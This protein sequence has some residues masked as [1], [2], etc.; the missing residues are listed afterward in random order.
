MKIIGGIAAGAVL[1]LLI[2][3]ALFGA[4]VGTD[5]TD[6]GPGCV[7]RPDA[8]ATVRPNEMITENVT[9]DS[10]QVYVARTVVAV[11]KGMNIR[12]R[13]I[14]IALAVAMQESTLNPAAVNGRS[15]GLFQQQGELYSDVIKT[16]PV[17]SSAAFYRVLVQRVPDYE[18]TSR[19][20]AAI[21]QEVQRA[22]A[23]AEPYRRWEKWAITLEAV[24]YNGAPRQPPNVVQCTTGVGGPGAVKVMRQ[25]YTVQLPPEAEHSGTLTFPNELTAKAA[26]A[27]LSQLGVTYAWGGGDASG[28]T[29]GKRDGGAG[30][31]HGDFNKVGFDCSGLMLYAFAQVGIVLP[32]YSGDQLKAARSVTNWD[33]RVPGDLLFWGDPVHHVAMYLGFINGTPLMIE[34]Q[35]SG[36]TV[37]VAPV[38]V[39]GDFRRNSVGRMWG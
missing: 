19:D 6:P 23:G 34:A 38:R 22:G 7:V 3:V 29:K 35:Q 4:A 11:G 33:A 25:G 18:D 10:N 15:V 17:D 26:A 36:T 5:N 20:F 24:L 2:G 31:R 39:G 8:S 37:H 21:A 12:H 30:D 1:L 14:A 9:L 27:A 28:P 13:G 16:D 32:H